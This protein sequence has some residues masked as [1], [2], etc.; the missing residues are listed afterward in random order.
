LLRIGFILFLISCSSFKTWNYLPDTKEEETFIY[1]VS[2]GWHTGIILAQENLGKDFEFLNS[3]FGSNPFYEF[4]WGDKGFYEAE[5][6][7]TKITLKAMF[8]PTESVLHVVAI[9]KDPKLYFNGSE[10]IKLPISKKA[11]VIL[12]QAILNTFKRS[13]SG[14]IIKTRVGIYGNSFF[15][16]ANGYYYITNTCNTW[17][18]KTLEEAGLP[19]DRFFTLTAR[20]VRSQA[21]DAL[22]KYNCCQKGSD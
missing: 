6:I 18:A 13:N 20:S 9:P 2:H 15:F 19:F 21:W 1:V 17:T 10:V 8:L 12:N 7:T 3:N 16:L 5:E 14:E 4:G 11:H 22:A